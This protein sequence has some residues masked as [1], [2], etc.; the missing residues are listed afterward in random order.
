MTKPSDIQKP[1]PQAEPARP[2][3]SRLDDD[4]GASS[5]GSPP[6]KAGSNEA[7]NEERKTQPSRNRG[8]TKI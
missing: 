1:A 3:A 2:S 4:A 7:L 8:V 6:P 5:S